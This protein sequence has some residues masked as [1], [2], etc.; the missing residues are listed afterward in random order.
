MYSSG[1]ADQAMAPEP[2]PSTPRAVPVMLIGACRRADSW[3]PLTAPALPPVLIAVPGPPVA[4]AEPVLLADAEP[5]LACF[6]VAVRA[7]SLVVLA[8]A[9]LVLCA[10]CAAA[11]ALWW[12]ALC[13]AAWVAVVPVAP[14]VPD[15]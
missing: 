11:F 3:L 15:A 12:V 1:G 10:L 4:V 13:A 6:A 7:R 2:Q 9:A 5:M 14:T 8:L